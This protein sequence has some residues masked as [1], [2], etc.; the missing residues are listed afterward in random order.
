VYVRPEDTERGKL[1]GQWPWLSSFVPPRGDE[2]HTLYA[3]KSK[4]EAQIGLD[5]LNEAS[6]TGHRQT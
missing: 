1:A 4:D 5:R 2:R 3:G 6:S